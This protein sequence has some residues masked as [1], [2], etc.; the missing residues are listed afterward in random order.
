MLSNAGLGAPQEHIRK[1]LASIITAGKFGFAPAVQALERFGQRNSI[2]GTKLIST[3]L[4]HAC[5]EDLSELNANIAWMTRRGY[6]FIYL[7]RPLNEIVV[8]SYIAYRMDKWHFFGEIDD[9]L[10]ARLD[11]LAFD[12]HAVWEEY[13][14]YRAHRFIADHI[15]VLHNMQLFAYS[16]V[17]R[18]VGGIITYLC[19]RLQV[20]AGSLKSRFT[21]IPTV[22]RTEFANL[23]KICR[24]AK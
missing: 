23:F 10:R 21:P 12:D 20:D 5:R 13:I 9:T 7:T 18:N 11:A 3:F 1:P 14:R 19:N 8:L 17:Q 6:Q 15:A 4:F 2:F 24:T 16:D 22:A